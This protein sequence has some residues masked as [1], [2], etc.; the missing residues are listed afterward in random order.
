MDLCV[1]LHNVASKVFFRNQKQQSCD[2]TDG[3][4]I[5]LL[6]LC[7]ILSHPRYILELLHFPL[8]QSPSVLPNFHYQ[9]LV[10]L[11]CLHLIDLSVLEFKMKFELILILL[12]K[13]RMRLG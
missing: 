3:N 1:L 8:G 4:K 11:A 10:G 5:S 7:P 12:Q 2:I 6:P 9:G 13:F